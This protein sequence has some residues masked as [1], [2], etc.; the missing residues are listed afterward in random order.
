MRRDSIFFQLLQQSPDLL[1]ALL[2]N[3]PAN[4]AHYRF[5]A[6][7][8]KEAKFEIDGVLLPPDSDGEGVIY[9]IE[10][11]FQKDERLYERLFAES[12]LYFY[13]NRDRYSGWQAI[14]V[15]PSR[16]LEQAET[17]PYQA[18]LNSD[19]VHRIFLDEVGDID[20]VSLGVALMLLTTIP[21]AEAPAA[22]RS[23]M[24][25][26]QQ[27]APDRSRAIIEMIATLIVYTFNQLSRLE[28]EAMLGIRL[29]ETRV[30]QEAKQDEALSLILRLLSRQLN[31]TLPEAMRAQVQALPLLQLEALGEALLSFQQLADLQHWLQQNVPAPS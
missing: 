25:R 16:A 13:R 20:Q 8:V 24:A 28:V 10:I 21:E 9:F 15:Y 22:A 31:Q 18:L 5:A 3:A 14:I 26:A 4:A 6:V 11:Q 23:L 12:L 27:E 19:Q 29:E 2:P 7:S 17:R 1:F 30:Y